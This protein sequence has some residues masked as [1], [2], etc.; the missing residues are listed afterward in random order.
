MQ[1]NLGELLSDL[2]KQPSFGQ[3]VN[4]RMELET[5]EDVPYSWREGLYV[6]S[7]NGTGL[8]PS[9]SFSANSA[10]T[11]ALVLARTQSMRRRTV[12]GNITFP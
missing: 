1:I 12:N 3:A 7:K 5:L 8:M 6:G 2:I 9:F 11:S 4:L 10:S